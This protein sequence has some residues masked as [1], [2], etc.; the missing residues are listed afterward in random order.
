MTYP[1]QAGN[2]S[3]YE[4]GKCPPGFKKMPS[5]FVE[6]ESYLASILST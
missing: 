1:I 3:N 5:L 2:P 4:N 6:S